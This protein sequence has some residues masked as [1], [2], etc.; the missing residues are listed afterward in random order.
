MKLYNKSEVELRA[1]GKVCGF[2]YDGTPSMATGKPL[3]SVWDLKKQKQIYPN[4]K[5]FLYKIFPDGCLKRE[6]EAWL[7]EHCRQPGDK[8]FPKKLLKKLLTLEADATLEDILVV[9]NK[10]GDNG[11]R[12]IDCQVV[13]KDGSRYYSFEYFHNNHGIYTALGRWNVDDPCDLGKNKYLCRGVYP[14]KK[15]V[16]EFI[17]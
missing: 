1:T 3:Y 6:C 15:V 16:L 9:E 4:P 2:L 5:E 13:F 17:R 7:K 12:T 11:G 8:V 10:K 14:Q